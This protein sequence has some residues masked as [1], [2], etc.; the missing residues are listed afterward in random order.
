MSKNANDVFAVALQAA[1]ITESFCILA[2]NDVKRLHK[3]DD[4]FEGRIGV[5]AQ[6]VEAAQFVEKIR[7][8]QKSAWGDDFPFPYEVWDEVAEYLWETLHVA[9]LSEEGILA[10]IKRVIEKTA[11]NL[12]SND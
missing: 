9:E 3:M 12:K 8:E 5:L 11:L 2:T 4:R 10:A 1:G 6:I 7:L